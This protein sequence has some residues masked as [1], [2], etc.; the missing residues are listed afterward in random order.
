MP[1]RFISN[2]FPRSGLSV[3]NVP[4]CFPESRCSK[5]TKRS[6]RAKVQQALLF[7]QQ[8]QKETR[9][10]NYKTSPQ[11]RVKAYTYF[12]WVVLMPLI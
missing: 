7:L 6:A 1:M 9:G 5:F 11:R 12:V 2:W 8:A 3:R 4:C 10:D